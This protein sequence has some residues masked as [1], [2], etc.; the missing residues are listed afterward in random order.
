MHTLHNT[1]TKR[2]KALLLALVLLV[3]SIATTVMAASSLDPD[4]NATIKL[5]YGN[6]GYSS[7][8][9]GANRYMLVF[10]GDGKLM[11]CTE[12]DKAAPAEGTYSTKDNK[13]TELKSNNAKYEMFVKTL[14]YGYGG[15]AWK[16]SNS[17]FATNT[18]KHA[19][20]MSGSTPEAFVTNLMYSKSGTQTLTTKTWKN[21]D[22][23]ITTVTSN[24][25]TGYMMTHFVFT[26]IMRG[27]YDGFVNACKSQWVV[28]TSEA[29]QWGNVVREFYNAI[30]KAPMP[31]VGK[32][33]YLLSVGSDKQ[34]M[35]LESDI[36]TVRP[37]KLTLIK[38][39]AKPEYTSNNP[40]YDMTGAKFGVYKEKACKTS[41][42]TLTVK[43]NTGATNILTLPVGKYYI[44]E[45]SSK[46]TGYVISTEVKEATVSENKLT[47]VKFAEDVGSDPMNM[48][49]RKYPGD[50]TQQGPS[51]AGAV[52]SVDFYA[53]SYASLDKLPSS[54]T[55]HWEYKTD[56]KGIIHFWDINY[57]AGG[58]PLYMLE[59]S[60][61]GRK[62]AT[63]PLGTIVVYE[64]SAPQGYLLGDG[65]V[66]SNGQK[67]A[68]NGKILIDHSKEGR[69]AS[70]VGANKVDVKDAEVKLLEPVIKGG[71]KIQ[72]WIK[73][74]DNVYTT[75]P[76]G[77]TKIGPVTYSVTNDNNYDVEIGGKTYKKGESVT[78]KT[79]AK[80][81]Y[82]SS[83]DFLPYGDY[84]VTEISAP[85]GLIANT[86]FTIAIRK[87]GE[88]L[89]FTNK[90]S[91]NN[92]KAGKIEIQKVDSETKTNT[93][94]GDA[95]LSGATFDIINRSAE[96]IYV[97]GKEIKPN[98]V[99][100][101]L[102][103][104]TNGHA[105][106][107]NRFLTYGTYEVVEKG[108]SQGYK[109]TIQGNGKVVIRDD[110]V[111]YGYSGY[112][113]NAGDNNVYE[114][115]IRGGVKIQKRD[116]E[117]K[118]KSTLG[119][120][121]FEGISFEI[122]NQSANAVI[123]DGKSYKTGSVVKTIVTDKNGLATTASNTLPY[124]TY[125]IREKNAPTGYLKEG[126][127]ERTF[128]I[129]ENG[130]IVDM[131][132]V[133]TSIQDQAVRGD[134]ALRKIDAET[135]RTMAYVPFKIT[136][137]TTGESHVFRTD[138]NG[139]YSSSSAWNKHTY[140]TNGGNTDSGLWFG[141]YVDDNG[142]TQMT[143]ANDSLGAL[144]YDTY[145]IEELRDESNIGYNLWSDEITISRDNYVVDMNNIEDTPIHI[146]TTASNK[147]NGTKTVPAGSDV[148]I[149][150]KVEYSGL[151]TG[152]TYTFVGVFMTNDGKAL[153]IDG[154]P[155][156][157]TKTFTTDRPNGSLDVEFSV[158]TTGLEGK[159]L[160][161][162]EYLYEGEDAKYGDDTYIA[163]HDD[164]SD[165]NQT[166]SVV[167]VHTTALGD[168]SNEH[169]AK[170]AE[171][172]VINDTVKYRGLTV[173]ETYDVVGK[174][175]TVDADGK[176]VAVLDADN[177]EV[178][179]KTTFKAEKSE[180]EVVVAFEFNGVNLAGTKVVAFEDIMQGDK[181]IVSHADINDEDQTVV[182]PKIGTTLTDKR[183]SHTVATAD[184]VTLVDKVDYSNLIAGKTYTMKGTLMVKTA[185]EKGNVTTEELKDKDGNAVTATAEFTPEEV[186]GSVNVEFKFDGSTFDGESL[187]AFED[188]YLGE[189]SVAEHKDAS[190][191]NQTIT[192]PSV[193]T[194]MT[195]DKTKSHMAEYAKDV[196]LVDVV[197]YTGLTPGVEYTVS[198]KLMVKSTGKAYVDKDGN[199][200][201]AETKFKPDKADGTVN[202]EFT[203][204]TTTLSGESLVAFEY[205]KDGDILLAT[206]ADIEDAD[207][208]VSILKIG[209]TL[210]D[211][212]GK[213]KTVDIAKDVTLVDTVS[214]EG[215]VP[216]QTY[217]ITGVIVDKDASKKTES[218]TA[219]STTATEATET[220]VKP[221]VQSAESST[222]PVTTVE[223]KATEA[224]EP[225]TVVKTTEAVN[226][227][228]RVVA[229]V[230]AEF[231]PDKA[232]GNLQVKFDV[233][234][235]KF[236]GHTL[237]A[238]ET[239]TD[240][241]GVV[242]G[243]HKDINDEGQSVVVKTK[244]V[245][246]TGIMAISTPLCVATMAALLM[247]VGCFIVFTVRR[248]RRMR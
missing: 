61:T 163:L 243:E 12:A 33:I 120:G 26:Y 100:W 77:D 59:G 68:D 30:S 91:V 116:Y 241:K 222:V 76:V 55:R 121:S 110:G 95:T 136:S 56:D 60:A 176:E 142:D 85:E 134:F 89:D 223:T 173:G 62:E 228:V 204:D 135:Q 93:P 182:F 158:N 65:F 21:I 227:D 189:T 244:P 188:C 206:H 193:R 67:I 83:S 169:I 3:S 129:R 113:I 214:Y 2:I 178:K 207:Q 237:V 8:N 215:L 57:Y 63:I 175:M 186:N 145:I 220:T 159:T 210:T 74:D 19:Q 49:I 242:L 20:H 73:A 247:S 31:D 92:D 230:T 156:T 208:T 232:D 211:K 24:Y 1:A 126:I 233:D 146:Y 152:K 139:Y 102:T 51:L 82:K 88:I 27:G 238:F 53:G 224:T 162:F 114:P 66:M 108:S 167:D 10:Y 239:V 180:G 104:D 112:K 35:I 164:I 13:L 46:I 50:G 165:V 40:L 94:Q 37:G 144:P 203:V 138:V 96:S 18:S 246:Q 133:N 181:L 39:S 191:E 130:K 231:K 23:T 148:T 240:D 115:V 141:Q 70:V 52:F 38:S 190:D 153:E 205:I 236:A 177:N 75:T 32:R 199:E 41:V 225:T 216:G 157:T 122:I 87:N 98:A 71:F 47:T 6:D 248:K 44:K 58:D 151:S 25:W 109:V 48:A 22:S 80:G 155:V 194:T 226:T 184:E 209:T 42:G 118:A 4:G 97:N 192:F 5:T 101:T 132:S 229:T 143:K 15:E 99:A 212:D 28:P 187:V 171:K 140:D 168:G 174:L 234:T 111:S 131:T 125:K 201:I 17:V 84:T 107:P 170:A 54:P 43:D 105:S 183:G 123:V 160:T 166:V 127:T 72:K 197:S 29:E 34:Q 221:S 213:S 81:Y 9:P 7:G 119:A 128:T 137:K 161:V 147:D 179:A 219:A 106:T 154:K 45:L 78:I 198:G 202:V 149:T 200:V 124:G 11:Y 69:L 235:T 86:K 245:V 90:S 172:V 196:K 16:K 218:A 64:K 195:S 103:T 185:D 14:Y 79:D 117:S 150:D 36:P 217:K